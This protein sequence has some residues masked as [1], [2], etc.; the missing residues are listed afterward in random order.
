M[1]TTHNTY[2]EDQHMEEVNTGEDRQELLA[3]MWTSDGSSMFQGENSVVD[4]HEPST[5]IVKTTS[6]EPRPVMN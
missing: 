6:K 4:F 5:D 2:R 1:L 3:G